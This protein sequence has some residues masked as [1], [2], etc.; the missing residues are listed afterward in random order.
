VKREFLL[1]LKQAFDQYSIQQPRNTMV[2]IDKSAQPERAPVPEG[3][4]A[5]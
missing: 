3:P 1:R 4:P 5:R 2:V